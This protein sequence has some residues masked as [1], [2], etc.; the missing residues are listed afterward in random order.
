MEKTAKQSATPKQMK[1]RGGTPVVTRSMGHVVCLSIGY[2]R[3]MTYKVAQ[4][5]V[6]TPLPRIRRS[7]GA[8]GFFTLIQLRQA[9]L[10]TG[11]VAPFRDDFFK[12]KD[13]APSDCT[14]PFSI[15]TQLQAPHELAVDVAFLLQRRIG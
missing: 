1:N 7:A 6:T 9:P 11:S 8:S 5:K 2:R 15:C 4:D 10:S 12:V 13:A 3:R 14:Q